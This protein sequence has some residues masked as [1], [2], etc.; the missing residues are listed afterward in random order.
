LSRVDFGSLENLFAVHAICG[1]IQ[2]HL[3]L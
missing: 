3:S 1:H 2:D